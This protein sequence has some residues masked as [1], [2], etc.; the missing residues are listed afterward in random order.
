VYEKPFLQRLIKEE[1]H[2]KYFHALKLKRKRAFATV[3]QSH[4]HRYRK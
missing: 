2:C 3:K 1:F 4:P